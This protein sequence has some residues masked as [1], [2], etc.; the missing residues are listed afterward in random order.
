[1]RIRK[2]AIFMVLALFCLNLAVFPQNISL[3]LNKVTVKEAMETLKKEKGYSFV[4]ASGDIDTQKI[5]TVGV[6][7]KPIG[8]A[9]KQIL[10]GQ[11]ISYEIKGKNIVVKKVVTS[12]PDNDHKKITGT[13]LDQTG[14]PVIGANIVEKGTTNGTITDINGSFSLTVAGNSTLAVSYIGYLPEE[15]SVGSQSQFSIRLKEDSQALDEVIVI[16]YGTAKRKDFTGS[17]TSIKLENS[18]VALAPNLNA[19]ESLKGNVSG[20]D[21]GYTSSAGSTPSMQVRGQNSISGSNDPLLVVDGVIFMGSINDINPNDIAS[22]D[23]LKDATSAAV[24]GSRS[25]NGVIIITTKKGRTGKPIINFNASGSMQTWHLRPDI[26]NGEQWLD[27]IA[28]RNSYKDYSFLT[29]QEK[30]NYDQGKEINWV[31]EVIRTGW[32]QNYQVAV[33]G[34]GEKMNYYLSAAYTGNEGILLGDDYNRT[35]V[36][37]KIST[38]ITN[39]LQI[40][41]DVAF[42]R[43]DYSGDGA[44]LGGAMTLSPYGMKYHNEDKGLLEKFPNG[45]NEN[46]NPLWGV[47]DDKRDNV[48]VRDNFR[49]NA[50]AEVKLPWVP[51]LSYRFNYSGTVNY[52]EESNFS[53]ESLYAP[54]GPYNDESRYSA[55]TQKNYLT[56][57]NGS[58]SDTKTTSW[59]VDN[60]LKYNNTFGKHTIDLT[61]VATRDSKRERLKNMTGTDFLANGNTILG[62]NGL[63]YAK[64]QKLSF[65][66]NRRA[67]IGYLG[68][69]SYSFADTYYLT[70]SYRRDGASVFGTENK[71]GNFAAI[72]A[73]W[74]IKNE[75]FLQQADFLSDLKLKLSWGKNGNQGLEPYG[76]L[77]TVGNGSTGG[78]FYGFGNTSLPSYGINQTAIG[79][80]LLGWETTEAWNAGFESAWLNNRLFFD[81]DVYFSRTYDQ[82][83]TRSIPVMTGFTK[84]FSSL[85]EVTNRGTEI[86]LRSVNLQSK[87][88]NWSTALTFWLNRNK[89]KHLYKE[90]LNGDGKED[91]DLGN[92]LFIG[93]SIHSIYGYKQDGIVQTGDTEYI[94]KNGV[95]AGTPKYVDMNGDGAIT[96]DD[97]SIIGSADPNFKLNMSNTF[98]YKN[99]ELYIMIT[100]TFGG[101]GYYQQ[102]NKS[103][104]MTCGG[105]NQFSSNS[106]YI[107]YWTAENQSN[108][109]PAPTFVGDDYFLGLQNR[110][111]VRIQDVSL[112]YTF[113]EP[114]VK[115]AR[116]NNMKVFFS[117]KNLATIS[118]WTG[119][120]PE[121]GSTII[122]G[123]YPIQTSLSLG[124]NLSF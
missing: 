69:V 65:K 40:G 1:M 59:V 113:R 57:A 38:D 80:A 20:L 78:V 74:R 25:A 115:K 49:A 104:Y 32:V 2:K 82:I 99:W 77:S 95:T 73:A 89:L 29:A 53:H 11:L 81:M 116:I 119:G 98:S 62:I 7:N 106:M 84:M 110:A 67:N 96:T 76:T 124:V 6:V 100:G 123:T 58:L 41:A 107:P 23:V 61:A 14:D 105:S 72:G 111:Y 114:W 70:A 45:Q 39:W 102:S 36:L 22:Y 52:R 108:K 12:L 122:S 43:S 9:V 91:D 56:N 27:A 93:H 24:Y 8:D 3:N 64:T 117:G 71:W 63:H 50:Y 34:A 112:S 21:I 31:D 55:A 94:Q 35:T 18:P 87:D 83:F 26:M 90:D 28:A 97:R 46:G 120:D 44:D 30:Q 17:V 79:N 51:G 68:R 48:D 88:W 109:Y 118:G 42:T 121:I 13:I 86:T 103:A 101:N 10:Q 5:V 47:Y 60:I 33:S 4:F 19:L 37:G 16:G 66:N 75:K 92:S 15:V 54:L 85:G